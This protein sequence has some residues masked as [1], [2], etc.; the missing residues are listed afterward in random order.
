MSNA[1]DELYKSNDCGANNRNSLFTKDLET[2]DI[3]IEHTG[4]FTSQK[5]YFSEQVQVYPIKMLLMFLL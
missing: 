5:F 3:L 4:G 1:I 2:V